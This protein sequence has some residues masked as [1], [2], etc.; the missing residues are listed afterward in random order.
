[1]KFG[2]VK[3]LPYDTFWEFVATAD[4]SRRGTVISG[5]G[6]KMPTYGYA[7]LPAKH[8]INLLDIGVSGLQYDRSVKMKAYRRLVPTNIVVSLWKAAIL[9]VYLIAFL[10]NTILCLHFMVVA[11]WGKRSLSFWLVLW[12]TRT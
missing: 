9:M 6:D 3:E 2:N 11:I 4:K 5:G 7:T 10:V 12:E 1:M 8:F